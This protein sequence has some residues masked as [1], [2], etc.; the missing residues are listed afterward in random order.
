LE[1]NQRTTHIYI[2][3]YIWIYLTWV[4]STLFNPG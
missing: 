3:I 4:F 2:Y 1:Q